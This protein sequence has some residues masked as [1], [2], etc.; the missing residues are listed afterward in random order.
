MSVTPQKVMDAATS[1]SVEIILNATKMMAKDETFTNDELKSIGSA[2][3]WLALITVGTKNDIFAKLKDAATSSSAMAKK[4]EQTDKT[5][6]A[7]SGRPSRTAVGAKRSR[8]GGF[9]VNGIGIIMGCIALLFGGQKYRA[10]VSLDEQRDII[11]QAAL[12]QITSACPV[13][14]RLPPAVS[15][16][17]PQ[18]LNAQIVAQHANDQATCTMIETAARNRVAMAEAA[19]EAALNQIPAG[20]GALATVGIV[21][22]GG[23]ITAASITAAAAGGVGVSQIAG[24]LVNGIL[25][26]GAQLT[27]FIKDVNTGLSAILPPSAQTAIAPPGQAAIAPPPGG[28]RVRTRRRKLTRR[29][30]KRRT[31]L[32]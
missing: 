16:L 21:A 28:K 22:A 29:S 4:L 5:A 15:R 31:F 30:T 2:M 8:R 12:Q 26:D 13:N 10:I 9:A 11:R 24:V 32:Y 27:T 23:P 14:I 20:I 19:Y 17:N 7:S 1:V 18:A 6:S 25:P 3:G